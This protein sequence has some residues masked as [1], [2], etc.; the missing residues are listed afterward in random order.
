MG[1][2][3]FWALALNLLGMGETAVGVWLEARRCGAH[4]LKATVSEALV[5]SSILE[6]GWKSLIRQA[7]VPLLLRIDMRT[8]IWQWSCMKFE[9]RGTLF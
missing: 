3:S 4:S 9:N 5:H 8:N 6:D 1:A 7:H 2:S